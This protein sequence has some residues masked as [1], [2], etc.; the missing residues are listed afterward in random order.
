VK[1]AAGA[2]FT[3]FVYDAS[4]RLVAEYGGAQAQAGGVSYLTQDTLGSARAVTGQGQEV[5]GRYDYLPFGEETGAG[6]GGRAQGQ[7]Y[8]QPD[9][10]RQK[11]TSAERD[12]EIG[13]DFMQARY[14]VSGM[15]RFTSVDPVALTVERL[16]DP[17]AES[18]YISYY[19][20]VFYHTA[21]CP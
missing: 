18:Y 1:K 20:P 13:L 11:F 5:R 9:G 15:G 21:N 17:G 8:S 16:Y 14:Y 7:G 10:V 3:V 2:S 19:T 6:V 12:D 4:G